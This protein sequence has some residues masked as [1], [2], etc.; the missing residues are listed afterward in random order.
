[1][2]VAGKKFTVQKKD[3]LLDRGGKK[4]PVSLGRII[5]KIGPNIFFLED[6]YSTTPRGG[7]NSQIPERGEVKGQKKKEGV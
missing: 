2:G 6:A 5:Q 3:T 1:L 7:K 4:N